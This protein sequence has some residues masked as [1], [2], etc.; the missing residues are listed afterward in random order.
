MDCTTAPPKPQTEANSAADFL[1]ALFQ[2][3][4]LMVIRPI[5]TWTENGQKKSKVDYRGIQYILVGLKDQAGAWRPYPEGLANAVKRHNR[6]AEQTKANVFFGVCPRFGAAGQYDQ[7]WQIRVVRTLW[8]DVDHCAVDEVRERCR[9]AGLPEPSA[10][11]ASGNGV[12]LYWMLTE[13]Y[14]ID[15]VSD[16]PPVFT[17]FIDQ[18]EGLKK[19]PRKYIKD[20]DGAKV[21]ID[22]KDKHNAP[23]LSAKA[24]HVQD[25][26]AGIA[27]KIGGDHTTDLSR[28]LRVPGTL[29]RKDQRNGR[30]PVRCTLVKCDP[31]RR[32]P[33]DEF[34][35]YAEASPDRTRREMIAKVKLPAPRK[36]SSPK[37][38]RF[39]ELLLI[40]DTADVGARSE[41]DFALCCWA[42]EHGVPR[43]SVWR[44]AQN[45]GKF[46]EAGERYF[47]RTWEKAEQHTRQ[48]IFEKAKAKTR[49]K[50]EPN[51]AVRNPEAHP[52]EDFPLTDT[53]NA[54][55]FALQH[56][57]DVRYCF[58]WGKWL[59]WDSTRWKIDNGGMVE[60]LG[61]QTVRS[62]L[63]EA[64]DEPDDD[65]REAIAKFAHASESVARRAAM[66]T[67]ARSEPPIPIAPD[68]LDKNQWIL[69]CP[70][71]RLDLR[72]GNLCDHRR[73]EFITKLCPVEYHPDAL[74]PTWLATLD[75]CFSRI[76]D[77]IDFVQ[78]F[79]GC[80]LTG[81]VSEQILCI[82]H[83]IGANGKSTILNAL[84][85]MLGSDYAMKAT[86]DLLLM[87]RDTDHPTGLTDLHG[88]RLV[89]C[90]ETDDN[91]RL[92]EALVKEL[93]GGDPIRARRM[94]EDFWQFMPTHKVVLACNHRP[95]VRGTDHAIWRRLKLVPFDVVIPPDERDKQ[96]PAKLRE[97]LPG[98]LAWA[99]RGCF[100]WQK[101][102]LGEPRAVIEA[103]ADYQNAEDVLLN[104]ISE[105]CVTGPE[106]RVKAADLL[107]AFK[108]W[109]GDR[110]ITTRRLTTMLIERGIERYTNNGLWYRGVGL[111]AN[112]TT[113][114]RNDFTP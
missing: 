80:S 16:P 92:A 61:K 96:L 104:F 9:A 97:E 49:K 48:K 114:Q 24:Q 100:D 2:P 6:R 5:E 26:L 42:V 94:R 62:I 67:L 3:S 64:A 82:W 55:R 57:D 30:E 73:E 91:R 84:M 72:T 63:H 58:A 87:K 8:T 59:C 103:T 77:L 33:I 101:H 95:A 78:R 110:H 113:E 70:N 19:K 105:C 4:D 60:Q 76:Y 31:T 74:C 107:S 7:A 41:A 27:S 108:E 46:R 47:D 89:A 109:S 34:A 52:N 37:L 45:V 40:C 10:I 75:K 112:G 86:A 1:Q 54:E 11:V 53:G 71:G 17:D 81:D 106:A 66:L 29:N 88:K 13:P 44:E 22:D 39:H 83:G 65:R 12:H 85:E 56:G 35:R 23:S 21:Y 51:A 43:E 68:A 32:Y 15:D 69:N 28:L 14:V 38:N 18:G 111:S 25:I 98:I 36:L 102:G 50:S 99:V 20:A 93:T 79:A 90:I